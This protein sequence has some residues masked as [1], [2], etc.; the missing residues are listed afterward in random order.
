M[1]IWAIC[2]MRWQRGVL[3]IYAGCCGGGNFEVKIGHTFVR[4]IIFQ[5]ILSSF[6]IL[7][8]SQSSFCDA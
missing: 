3:K 2:F 4:S 5:P 1:M 8:V 6:S 7:V